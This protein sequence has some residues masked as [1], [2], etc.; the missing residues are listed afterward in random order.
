MTRR[1]WLIVWAAIAVVIWNVVFDL[2][3]TRGV[4]HALQATAEAELG[5]AAPVAIT[6]VLRESRN[7]GLI[8]ASLCAGGVFVAGWLS[9]RQKR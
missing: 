3:M 8:A 9:V 4:R 7:E 1:A 5:W 2:Y 6:D